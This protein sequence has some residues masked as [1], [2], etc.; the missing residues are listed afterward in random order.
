MKAQ[1]PL[2]AAAQLAKVA[3]I[4]VKCGPQ[5]VLFYGNSAGSMA[6]LTCFVHFFQSKF[7]GSGSISPQLSKNVAQ[8]T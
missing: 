2:T 3:K 1:G 7:A 4:R 6:L 5:N 8:E